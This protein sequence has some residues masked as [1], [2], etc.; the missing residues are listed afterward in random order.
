[1]ILTTTQPFAHTITLPNAAGTA[2]ENYSSVAW[3]L[4]V[5]N[6]VV[7]ESP[8][9]ANPATGT[10]TVSYANTGRSAGDT[11]EAFVAATMTD[12]RVISGRIGA[13]QIGPV[14]VSLSAAERQRITGESVI[15][16]VAASGGD[17][18]SIQ[19]AINAASAGWKIIVLPGTYAEQVTLDEAGVELYFCD[20]AIID[21]D[22]TDTEAA[23]TV[24]AGRVTGHGS[25]AA[26]TV[27]EADAVITAVSIATGA[28][29]EG[30][31]W[32]CPGPDGTYTQTTIVLGGTGGTLT[33]CTITSSEQATLGS[34]GTYVLIDC[35][36]AHSGLA[37]TNGTVTRAKEQYLDVSVAS[38]GT[39]TALDAAGVRTAVGLATA[40]LD[41]QLADLPTVA[42]FE[43]RTIVSAD[44]LVT[45][46]LSG[47][48]TLDAAGIRTALGLASANLDTQLA[49]LPTVAEFEA[50]TIVAADY[51]VTGD[52]SGLA[53]QASVNDLPTNAELATALSG[54]ATTGA[55]SDTLETLSDQIDAVATAVGLLSSGSGSG[56]RTVTI[57]VTDGTDPLENATVNLIEGANTYALTTSALGVATFTS[58]QDATYTVRVAKSGYVY[59]PDTIEV[60]GDETK[61]CAMTLVAPTIPDDPAQC[62]LYI[63][64]RDQS[65]TPL[66]GARLSYMIVTGPGTNGSSYPDNWTISEPS[67]ASTGLLEIV[68]PKSS[69]VR[70]RRG[71]GKVVSV[72]VLT[73]ATQVLP[74]ILGH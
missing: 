30:L 8:T 25:I 68:V 65:G 51:V 60:D 34:G 52:L 28:I 72:T 70:L 14:D 73:A 44:Y 32:S 37:T 38:R 27:P 15:K 59:T 3:T 42:E 62:T 40:N 57:T 35:T 56:V 7:A 31:T 41:T 19:T 49:D 36:E 53:T 33:G 63:I 20:G 45:G 10:Y 11:C 64:M 54:I 48:S 1:M 18:T 66:S 9:V 17:Y 39:G 26:I 58:M 4:R 69:V 12:G 67:A 50:R 24:T 61:T 22:P 2:L 21:Y 6:T 46:D 29:I 55:D 23:L 13:W 16:L 47:L 71:D 5:N 43:A 74:E